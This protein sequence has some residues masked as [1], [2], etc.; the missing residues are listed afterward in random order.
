MA[1]S[2]HVSSIGA[3]AEFR[4]GL[5]TFIEEARNA[6][7]SLDMEIRRVVDWVG[8]QLRFWKDEMREA[9]D[10]VLRARSELSRRKMMR[11]GDRPIDTTEQEKN[12]ARARRRLEHAEEKLAATKHWILVLPDEI[13]E[14]EGP[15]R[16]FQDSVESDLPKVVAMLERKIAALEAYAALTAPSTAPQAPG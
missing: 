5:C 10:D 4:A 16:L 15:S 3:L 11:V 12:L 1:E 7:V 9:E 2:A 8:D 13:R 14:F 6:M